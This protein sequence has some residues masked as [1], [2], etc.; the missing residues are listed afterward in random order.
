MKHILDEQLLIKIVNNLVFN[1]MYYCSSVWCN[2]SKK[3]I[4]KSQTV[5][6]FAARIVTKMKKYDHMTPALKQLAWLPVHQMLR[7]RDCTM[8]A[9]LV[10]YVIQV[11]RLQEKHK[12]RPSDIVAMDKTL[13][14]CDMISETYIDTERERKL[15]L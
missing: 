2:A 3:N 15:L 6:N 12:Y 7:L 10:S 8:V 5:Q 14:W 11:R 1:R 9:K 13:V 4:A